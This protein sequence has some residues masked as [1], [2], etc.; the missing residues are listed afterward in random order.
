MILEKKI[1]PFIRLEIETFSTCNRRCVTCLRNSIPDRE[2]VSSWFEP[3]ALPFEDIRRI[4]EEAQAMGFYGEVC[5]SHYNEPLMDERIVEIAKL[6]RSMN[7]S[8]VFFCS[9]ADFLTEELASQ[10]DGLVNDIGFSFYMDEP[11]KSER[12]NWCKGLFRKTHAKVGPGDHMVTHFS[13]I[14]DVVQIS[15]KYK[16]NPCHLP[17]VRM[18]VNHKGQMLLCCDD[19]TGHFNLGTIYDGKTIEELWYGDEHQEYVLA[20]MKSGGRSIHPHCQSCPRS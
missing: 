11:M 20:L 15:R 12:M 10:L 17:Q 5:L 9:N 1:Q 8:R 14:H 6:A 19:L 13:P 18:I 2:S 7:F 16:D 3:K 4:M